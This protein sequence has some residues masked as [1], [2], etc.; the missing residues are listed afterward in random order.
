M[1]IILKKILQNLARWALAK[2][3]IELIVVTGWVGV[4]LAKEGIYTLLKERYI[5]RRNTR[6]VWW[7]F[8]VPL[9]ILGFVDKRRTF[10]G[11]IGLICKSY[12]LLLFG[13]K[14]KHTLILSAWSNNESTAKYWQKIVKPDYLVIVNNQKKSNVT[15]SLIKAAR[16]S[17]GVIIY[18][19]AD[20][21][22]RNFRNSFIYGKSKTA[23]VSYSEDK[24]KIVLKY[25]NSKLSIA[26]Y[27]MPTFAKNIVAAIVALS[28]SKGLS[29]EDITSGLLK[30]DL[31]NKVLKKISKRIRE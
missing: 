3:D 5:V 30:F 29:I 4:D 26:K 17:K 22:K 21:K 19:D 31:R 16:K 23:R 27:Y 25:N 20:F 14:S 2:H 1:R 9:N 28:I 13:S 8:S 6:H 11:W 15:D 12:L 24:D 10:L 18:D 7:D